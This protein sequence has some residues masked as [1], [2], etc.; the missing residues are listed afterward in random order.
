MCIFILSAVVF[1]Y[2]LL[3]HLLGKTVQAV[4]LLIKSNVCIFWVFSS[5]NKMLLS[6]KVSYVHQRK[7]LYFKPKTKH[8]YSVFKLLVEKGSFK[9]YVYLPVTKCVFF[10]CTKC[11]SLF[12]PLDCTRWTASAKKTQ[13]PAASLLW[14]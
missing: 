14:V 12:L 13:R 8:F 6:T 7:K 4:K 9:L 3:K 1:I 2:K 10:A 11:F 5:W